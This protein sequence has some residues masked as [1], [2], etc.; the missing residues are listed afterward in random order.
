MASPRGMRRSSRLTHG[1]RISATM[2]ATIRTS[3]TVPDARASAQTP[4]SASGSSTSCTQRG[5]TTGGGL[6][7]AG[8][9]SSSDVSW[10][11]SRPCLCSS[12]LAGLAST[13]P[14]VRSSV[15]PPLD[16]A[17]RSSPGRS[18]GAARVRTL[19]G[20]TW[21]YAPRRTVNDKTANILFIGDIVGAPGKHTLL[22]LLPALRERFAP[23]FVVVNG[24]NIAGG[25]GIT[26]KLAD[27]MFDAGIDV[28]TL[29]NH[30]YRKREIYTYLDEHERILRPANF[31]RRQPGHG[32]CVVVRDEIRLGV[33]SLS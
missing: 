29:G 21:K 24:E 23:S 5:T 2:L 12:S 15:G 8:V 4:R 16:S 30:T 13:S 1:A 6:G 3:R 10:A 31:L 17:D 19:K 33:V 22:G 20:I 32:W 26:P 14:S 11:A 25:I 7:A 9:S 27:Q 18:G 28:I